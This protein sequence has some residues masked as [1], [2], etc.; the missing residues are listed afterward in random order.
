MTVCNDIKE[1]I[2]LYIEGESEEDDRLKIESHITECKICKQYYNEMK[3][4]LYELNN[5]NEIDI[6]ENLHN[7][8]MNE[9]RKI[10][11]EQKKNKSKRMISAAACFIGMCVV[12]FTLLDIQNKKALK[13]AEEAQNPA[14]TRNIED[15]PNQG[16]ERQ[17]GDMP[18]QS[19]QKQS[20]D[21]IYENLKINIKSQDIDKIFEAAVFYDPEA[22]LN[23]DNTIDFSILKYDFDDFIKKL[24][25][26]GTAEI[27]DKSEQNKTDEYNSIFDEIDSTD[28][29]D[30]NAINS[31]IE[32]AFNME[33][34]ANYYFIKIVPENF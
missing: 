27:T 32:K 6:P 1:K 8:I 31:L 23:D 10:N 22:V 2:S 33:M 28:K 19:Y 25:D 20:G 17:S 13:L 11:I 5:I 4:I 34:S 30:G 7:N 14:L 9:V 15:M 12:T 26:I 18:A 29:Q 24:S 3:K 16:Y 21:I